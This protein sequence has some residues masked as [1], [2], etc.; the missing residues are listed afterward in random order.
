MR[1]RP[2]GG[3]KGR[4]RLDLR[5]ALATVVGV[6]LLLP[7]CGMGAD[8]G[9]AD[10]GSS[11]SPVINSASPT[12]STPED[13]DRGSAPPAR[14]RRAVRIAF[15]G[16]VHFAGLLADR[17]DH[18]ATA[19][20]PMSRVLSRADLAIVN[21]ETAVTT[22]GSPEPKEFTFRAPPAAFTALR[23]AGIDVVTMANNHALD[24]GPVSVPDALAAARA[25]DMPVVGIGLNAKQAYAP[26]ITTVKGRR[27]AL[28]G[29]SAVIDASLV[30]SWSAGPHQPGVATALDGNND[31][32]VAAVERVRPRVDTVIV[33]LHYGADLTPCPT[34]IQ[35]TL[36]EDLAQAGADVV[37]GQHAHILLGGGYL[38][39]TYVDYG[40][41]NFDFYVSGKG[42]TAETGVLLL[43]AKG[44]H[45][46]SPRW[47]PG[48]IVNGVANRLTGIAAS[49]GI[50]R[51]DRLRLCAGL[52]Q[53]PS[54]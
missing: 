52:A 50:D 1:L 32:L 4:R 7:A 35:R 12:A 23:A 45:I 9:R 22:S 42:P 18:P 19:I 34:Q 8:G 30:T 36:A 10:L 14:K 27:I 3:L 54:R 48:R 49:E 24:Y 6:G 53:G 46:S 17:L 21:L 51:K 37:V 44:R 5:V 47:V 41:G 29:A 38:G 40:L 31:A 16:D 15:A 20:G 2:D 28:F 13:G 25:A 26:W 11:R 43:T 39:S 33:D